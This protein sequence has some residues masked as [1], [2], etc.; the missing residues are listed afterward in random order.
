MG[1][2]LPLPEKIPNPKGKTREAMENCGIAI[3]TGDDYVGYTLPAG[4]EMVD[5][6]WRM[7]LPNYYMVDDQ[8]M[9]RFSISG[10]W[11]GTYDNYLEIKT[12]QEPHKLER[13]EK[14]PEPSQTSETAMR[15]KFKKATGTTPEKVI[16]EAHNKVR[17]ETLIRKYSEITGEECPKE[18]VSIF[19]ESQD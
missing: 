7:D 1:Q 5:V 3:N 14:E 10:S 18:I 15:E 16:D 11:K 12:V 13:R 19:R 17:Q 6:S 9:A 2:V 4:W 8:G